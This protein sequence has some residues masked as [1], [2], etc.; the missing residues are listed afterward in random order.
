MWSRVTWLLGPQRFSFRPRSVEV[1]V[2]DI[3]EAFFY[4]KKWLNRA[5]ALLSHSGAS[6]VWTEQPERDSP[7]LQL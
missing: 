4:I 5:W 3:D 2:R 1:Y 7:E 6:G